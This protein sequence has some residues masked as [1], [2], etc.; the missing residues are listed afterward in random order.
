MPAAF[1]PVILSGGAGTRL[2]PVSREALPK[3]FIRLADGR[4][5]LRRTH[6][7]ACRLGGEPPW[8]ITNRDYYFLSHDEIDGAGADTRYLLEPSGRNT[9]PAIA[10]AALAVAERHGPD[11]VLLVLPADHLI[12]DEPGFAACVAQARALAAQGWLTTFGLAAREPR[13][14]YGYLEA[15]EPIGAGPGRRVQRFVE[16]PSLETAR[17]YVASGRHYWNSGMFCFR[18]REFLA[19]LETCA[20]VLAAGAR[21]CWAASTAHPGTLAD[22][23]ALDAAC[24][25]ALENI[26]V[27]Y[28]VFEKAGGV[29]VVPGDFGWSDVGAWPE[30][31]A[32][33][34]PD[35]RG[36]RAAG[37]ALFI[38]SDQCFVQADG[39]LVALL[40]QRDTVV[41]DTADALLVM[42]RERA[43]DV[44]Q[45]VQAL[46]TAGNEKYLHHTT[47]PR[48]WG[49]YTT[50][51]EAPWFKIKR[52]EVR[53][54]ASLS[55][56]MH[57]YRSEHWVVVSGTATVTNGEREFLL[58]TNESTYIPSG[59]LHRLANPGKLPLVL[60][61]VQSGQY[62]GEDDIVRYD[63]RYGR[64]GD[65]GS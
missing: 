44:K 52:V 24:F 10:L 60:I 33:Y 30:I 12:Q 41:V 7:R 5:L 45:V 32:Q 40:G 25:G 6:E 39:R 57:H 22:A 61:E 53:P 64:A 54:G 8:L 23:V 50:L 37:K 48:P 1:L 20:P 35:A 63:D 55:L 38:D 18:A 15:G 9:A 2:W 21:A 36:N 47:V 31:A 49:S 19:A 59:T 27:D 62:L 29:A 4:S 65:A 56:Q 46:R 14:A 58:R 16:K 3:P 26:S 51:Q 28:A 11:A 34:E 43:Q 42:P 17:D 13:T